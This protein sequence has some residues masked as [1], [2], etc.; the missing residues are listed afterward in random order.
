[1]GTFDK[2][3]GRRWTLLFFAAGQPVTIAVSAIIGSEFSRDAPDGPVLVPP[4]PAFAIWGLIV[5]LTGVYAAWQAVARVDAEG[6]GAVAGPLAVTA[7][8][9]CAWIAFASIP[10]LTVLTVPVFLVMGAGLLLAA[11]A[12]RRASLASWPRWVRGVLWAALGSY[13]GWTAIA[14][15]LNAWTVLADAGAPV[16]GEWGTAWQLSLAAAATG[17]AVLVLL[18]VSR[19]STPLTAVFGVTTVYALAFAAVGATARDAPVPALVA[20]GLAVIL[21]AATALLAAVRRT[22]VTRR[23]IP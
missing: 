10:A 3:A 18:F 9:F 12:T 11:K 21:A 20:A 4:G 8:C 13:L 7:A 14:V 22:E 16:R 1:M 5:T 15:W 2:S 23:S 17:T 19:I 6:R